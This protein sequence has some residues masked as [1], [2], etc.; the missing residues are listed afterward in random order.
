[1]KTKLIVLVFVIAAAFARADQP[2]DL[3]GASADAFKPNIG[4]FISLRGRLEEG[5]QGPNLFGATPT[6]VVFYV[7]AD[8][9]KSGSYSWPKPWNELRHQQVR[10]T[11]DLKFQSFDRKKAGLFDQIPPDYYYMVTQHPPLE[12]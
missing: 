5:M 2:V 4:H 7:I 11:G 8:M 1:M 10:V 9:P 12:P 6:N 3:T